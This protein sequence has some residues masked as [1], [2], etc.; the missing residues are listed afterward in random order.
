MD[1]YKLDSVIDRIN[2]MVRNYEE[3]ATSPDGGYHEFIQTLGYGEGL[4]DV[5][6]G[7]HG[8]EVDDP[9]H[10]EFLLGLDDRELVIALDSV[11][12][13]VVAGMRLLDNELFSLILGEQEIELDSELSRELEGLTDDERAYISRNLECYWDGSS[14]FVYTDMC[15]TRLVMQ[16]DEELLAEFIASEATV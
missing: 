5:R 3:N 14:R 11:T 1:T 9:S 8:V 12:D 6:R 4:G 2:E 16:L 15:D 10:I 7:L 13:I